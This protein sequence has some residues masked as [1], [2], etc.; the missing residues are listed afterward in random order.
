MRVFIPE[1]RDRKT[2]E[3]KSSSKYHISFKDHHGVMRRVV[4]YPTSVGAARSQ[5]LGAK[6]ESLV[7]SRGTNE[8]LSL[9]MQRWIETMHPDLLKKLAGWDIVDSRKMAALKPAEEHVDDWQIELEAKGNTQHRVNVAVS[10]ARLMLEEMCIDY[11]TDIQ[12]SD[13]QRFMNDQR[14]A[15]KAPRTINGYLQAFKQFCKWAVQE[16]RLSQSPVEHVQALSLNGDIRRKRSVFSID[17]LNQLI[18][19]TAQS[20]DRY[21]IRGFERAMLYRFAVETGYRANEIRALKVRDFELC[22][23][24]PVV[25]LAGKHTKNRNDAVLPLRADT[26]ECLAELFEGKSPS[27]AA[28]NLPS[29]YN[30][31]K[32]L[33]ADAEAAGLETEGEDGSRVDF[34][35]LRHQ[36]ATL[37]CMSGTNLKVAQKLMRHS[38]P[39]LTMGVYTHQSA[40]DA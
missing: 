35:S 38:D 31:A 40:S 8:M 28:F 26:A 29:K 11:L 36:S 7:S 17:E 10:R 3:K 20:E 19:H 27:E 9:D 23:D 12:A 24:M 6:I 5:A 32:M 21:K 22:E 37:H 15:G 34:H 25:K 14:K 2:G 16:G 30:M 4:A 13:V 33:R 18:E 39:K 1:Y